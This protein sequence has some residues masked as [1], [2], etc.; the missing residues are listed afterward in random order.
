MYMH[1]C[2]YLSDFSACLCVYVY[3]AY[4]D[5]SVLYAY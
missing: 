1:I 2:M 3:S 4:E 5:C